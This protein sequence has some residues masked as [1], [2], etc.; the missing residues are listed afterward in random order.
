MK[1]FPRRS[2]V[3]LQELAGTTRNARACM[4][5]ME[6]EGASERLLGGYPRSGRVVS[7]FHKR[8]LHAAGI[9]GP[10][11]QKPK[12]SRACR[13][14]PTNT[15]M[16]AVRPAARSSAGMGGGGGGGVGTP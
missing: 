9:P 2:C 5:R 10:P 4:L 7:T 12:V 13:W 14:L 8:L 3:N 6:R 1:S 15:L 11:S 16:S